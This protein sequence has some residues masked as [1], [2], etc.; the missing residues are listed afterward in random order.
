MMKKLFLL[1]LILPLFFSCKQAPN[2]AENV[3]VA[4]GGVRYGGTFH[5][6][7]SEKVNQLF[8]L[9]TNDLYSSRIIAQIFEGLVKIEPE[10]SEIIPSLAKSIKVNENSTVFTFN[11]RTNVYFQDDPCFKGGKGRKVT[12]KDFKYSLT[13]ACSNNKLNHIPYLLKGKIQGA[14]AY[15]NGQA[16]EVS[17]IKAINDSVLEITLAHPFSGFAA[18]LTHVG[19]GVFPKEAYEKYKAEIGN[20]PVGTGAFLLEEL[21]P[22]K[23][24]LERNNN[25]W[26][27]DQFGNPLPYLSKIEM[28]YSK[29]K[30]SEI[31]AFRKEKNDLVIGIP[32]N[33]IKYI[34]GSLQEAKEGKNVKHIIDS[35]PSLSMTYYGFA[36]KDGIFSDKAI[37][38]AFNLAIDRKTIVETDLEGEGWVANHGFVPEM[39]GYPIEKVKGFSYQPEK[40]KALL[41][42]AG[43]PNGAGFPSINLYVNTTKETIS[44]RL[45]NAIKKYLK[46]NLNVNI[47]IKLVSFSEREQAIKD[48]DAMFWRSAWIADYPDPENF[49]NLFYSKNINEDNTIINPFKYEN[50]KFDKLFEKALNEVNKEKRM[51]ILAQ[52]DQ[53]IVDDAVVM[54]LITDDFVT[55]VNLRVRN[56][57][58][59]D[60]EQMDFSTVYIKEV[61]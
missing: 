27:N 61:H 11:L 57:N 14:A 7:S 8:P 38:K 56:F 18:I 29:N 41:A 59:N 40:A 6:M 49:L 15:Y 34:L 54:P 52:C 17:G 35:Q 43:F 10:T 60:M 20:H 9:L 48:G 45:A 31:L 33:E 5:F 3:I 36:V 22:E 26:R 39:E 46:K 37:R 19:L 47:N 24:V 44:Y 32:V 13:F 53:I 21:T 1:L 55:M 42:E 28:T 58:T 2:D 51:D 4:K 30:T 50:P 25:Y 16:D 23:I 12:A